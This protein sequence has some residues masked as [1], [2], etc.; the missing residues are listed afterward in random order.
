MNNKKKT[1]VLILA[2]VMACCLG[3]E[4]YGAVYKDDTALSYSSRYGAKNQDTDEEEANYT[5]GPGAVKPAAAE[6]AETVSGPK[7][8]D[9]TMGES[10]HEEFQL[11]EE[12]I[13]GQ[14]FLYSNVANGG[15][16]DEPVFVDIP[17]DLIYTVEKDG[18]PIP[19]TSRQRLGE[20]GTYVMRFTAVYDKT[21]PL[22]EQ[23]EY[24]AVFRFRI[25]EKPAQTKSSDDIVSGISGMFGSGIGGIGASGQSGT[26]ASGQDGLPDQSGTAVPGQDGLPDQS[27]TEATGQDGTP[28]QD[29]TG[30]SGQDE[31]GANKTET[32]EDPEAA[33]AGAQAGIPEDGT[34]ATEPEAPKGKRSQVYQADDGMYEIILEDGFT[35]RSSVP[36]SMITTQPVKLE[37][38]EGAGCKIYQGEEEIETEGAQELNLYGTYRLVSGEYEF[39]FE[40]SNGYT[41]QDM[42]YSPVG[43]KITEAR[44]QD[45]VIEVTDS[46]LLPM[47]EDGKYA[48]T[49]AGDGG[50]RLTVI[51]TRDT[52]APEVSV[53]LQRQQAEISYLAQDIAEI[54]LSKNGK[55]PE[56]FR[57]TI[58][59]SPGRYTLTV[60]DRAGNT[61]ETEFRLRFHLNFYAVA[62]ILLVIAGIA[63][64]VVLLFRK[65]KNLTVR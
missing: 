53:T 49:M 51:L 29:G 19:Y 60:T 33:E 6:E 52:A 2:G 16:T 31:A 59:T 26:G 54:T 8:R 45:A 61:A 1:G 24:R 4:V 7:V 38:E 39:A 15:L 48:I 58:I 57:G 42:F 17:A 56:T 64:V 43:T 36:E 3:T 40:I 25:D 47:E 20:K 5:S 50:E 9:V 63:A 55:A 30:I 18:V 28:D 11:Y 27:G 21:V 32:T 35:F 62:A 65:K 22:A 37:L 13:N 44:F 46:S 12:S 14:Y 23:E 10:Y 34:E 41:N